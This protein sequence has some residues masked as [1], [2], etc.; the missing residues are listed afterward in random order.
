M[1][2]DQLYIILAGLTALIAAGFVTRSKLNY[3]DDVPSGLPWVGKQQG[4]FSDLRTRIASIGSVLDT[5]EAGYR[6]Y[7]KAGLNFVLP[8]FD[9]SMVL[10]PVSQVKWI[11]DQAEHVLNANEMQREVLQTDYTLLDSTLARNPIHELVVRRDLTRYLGALI[12]DIEDELKVGVDELWGKDTEKWTDV[13]VFSTMMKIVARTSNRLF[14]GLPLCRNDEYLDSAGGFAQDIP[15]SAALIRMIPKILKPFLSWIPLLSNRWHLYKASKYLLPFIRNRVAEL[16]AAKAA[17]EKVQWNDFT[18]W[19]L[20][21]VADHPD[22]AERTPEKL[23]KRLMVINFAAIHTSTFT[24]TNIL[25][26][27]FSSPTAEAD[28]KEIREEIETVLA[29]SNGKWNKDAVAKLIKTDSA[30]RE[31]LRI[32]TFMSHGMDRMVVDPKGVTMSDGL[33]LPQGT[34]IG[35]STYSIHHDN[36]VYENAKTYDAFRFSRVRAGAAKSSTAN[37]AMNKEYLA[38]VL[39]AKNLSTV[40]TSDTFLSFGHGRHACPG[41][42]FAATEMKLL[43]AYIIMNYDV[44]PFEKRP[45]NTF[46]AGSILPPMKATISVKRRKV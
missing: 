7:S 45:E 46:L 42:F 29:E 5:I 27:L 17:G 23:V 21:T 4:I 10:V 41:R 15:I 22:P 28:V 33:H 14:V 35:T 2:F 38:K 19:Y 36:N 43:L 30:V 3:G 34:R 13:V 39:E 6:K 12:P 16:D 20:K 40:T 31:S 18:G 1:A 24:A 8:G 9:H 25:F 11:V 37:G 44:K 32:S 26:D